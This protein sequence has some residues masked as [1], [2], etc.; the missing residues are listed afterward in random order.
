[1]SG[2][3]GGDIYRNQVEIDFSVNINPLGMPEGVETALH[4]A[5]GRCY[6]YPDISS[7]KLKKAVSSA[8]AVKEAYI[9]FGN[10]AS[11]IFMGILHAVKPEK[12]LIPVP[13]FYGY[14]HAAE[15]VES[16]IIYFP[17]KEEKEFSPEEDLLE[18]LTEDIDLLF[19][20]NPNNPTGK[21]MSREY[22]KRLLTICR[23]KKILV[24]L[25]ECFIEYCGSKYSMLA[26]LEEYDN[27]MLV[28]AFTK[29]Y[30]IPGVRLGYLLCSNTALLEGI[31]R[32]LP[33]W[34]M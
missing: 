3:H 2:I 27:L 9:L 10:G 19:L 31:R 24:V 29:I 34:I 28:R 21:L 20:A 5:V 15:A 8:M 13:S 25:D 26:E 30:A 22:L 7:E 17:L 6:K 32:Q 23:E 1:M 4:E 11:E 12:V 16:E 33:E 14:E 18:V